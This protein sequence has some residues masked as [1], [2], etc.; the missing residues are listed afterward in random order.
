MLQYSESPPSLH[1]SPTTSDKALPSSRESTPLTP[2][3]F[4][5][6]ASRRSEKDRGKDGHLPWFK[7]PIDVGTPTTSLSIDS[8]L[9]EPDFDDHSFPLF[10]ASP[11][12]CSMAGTAAPIDIAT[13]QASTSPRGPQC[14]TLT[15]ALQQRNPDRDARQLPGA[16]D[17]RP[18][19]L[20]TGKSV[21]MADG[22]SLSN[23]G[24]KPISMKKGASTDKGRRESVAQSLTGGMS[25]G[26]ISVGSWIRDE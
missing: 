20:E 21:N 8:P 23:N 10:G 17:D 9:L 16:S 26:G 18:D 11:P 1:H 15:S 19:E 7:R 24:A 6:S 22:A 14:S 12:V 4:C 13:R 25:W 5:P 3:G 2:L